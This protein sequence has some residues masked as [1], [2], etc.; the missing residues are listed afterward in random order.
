MKYT[1]L[2]MV[3]TILSR[4]DSD[5]VNS[6]SDTTE[7]RQVATI[8]RTA[9]FNILSRSNLKKHEQT[10]SL[11]SSGSSSTPVLMLRPDN[12][13]RMDWIKYYNT[14]DTLDAYEYVTVLPFEQ[15]HDL[16]QK[17]GPTGLNYSSMTL[18]G[19]TYYFR[20]DIQP[21]YC[22][23]LQN[24]Y[25]IFNG[26][27][28]TQDTTLQSSKTLCYGQIIPTFTLSD[29][30]IP[31][32]DD[33]QFPLLLSESTSA[34]SIELKQVPNDVAERDSKRQWHTLQRS[35][36]L[37]NPSSFDQLPYFGRK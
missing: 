7:S 26:Y 24:Y 28:S 2:D 31:D 25:I 33:E 11:D 3:Q 18:N 16:T 32:L 13:T 21:Y 27:D 36:D 37:S 10:F 17:D 15:Y 6:Y 29:T 4:L 34:A 20:T 22:T 8:I 1:L 35:K 9:Y 19:D 14:K 12:V 30:F 5:E 23:V